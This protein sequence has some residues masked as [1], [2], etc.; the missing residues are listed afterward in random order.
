MQSPARSSPPQAGRRG[1]AGGPTST[2][3]TRFATPAHPLLNTGQGSDLASPH[4][5][6]VTREDHRDR[7][8]RDLRPDHALRGRQ[9]DQ[10]GEPEA[11]E[12]ARQVA[13]SGPYH[14]AGGSVSPASEVPNPGG[15]HGHD[16]SQL[17]REQRMMRESCRAF[18]NDF[19]TPYI[20]QNCS[21]E[22]AD[23]PDAR[24]RARYSSRPTRSASA[25]GVPEEFRR[26]FR[27]SRARSADL[28]LISE[29][30]ARGRLGSFRQAGT[31][32][33]GLVLLRNVAPRH[34]R[35]SGSRAS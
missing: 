24:C 19:V 29:E 20:R 28:A 10:R 6:Y 15:N 12:K 34:Y 5:G 14:G 27:S 13:S 3:K 33:E 21:G 25:P 4:L 22:W 11:L 35:N 8:R 31:D 16:R 26:C 23:G 30:I 1:K 32:L 17:V 7:V 18:V 9:A 2:R